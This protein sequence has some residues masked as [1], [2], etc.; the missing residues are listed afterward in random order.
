MG[1]LV[2]LS[3]AT[4]PKAADA[5]YPHR[6]TIP[7]GSLGTPRVS[8]TWTCPSPQ[9]GPSSSGPATAFD[10]VVAV[11]TD[12]VYPRSPCTGLI[13]FHGRHSWISSP[14]TL[15]TVIARARQGPRMSTA[16]SD[17]DLLGPAIAPGTCRLGRGA[18]LSCQSRRGLGSCRLPATPPAPVAGGSRPRGGAGVPAVAS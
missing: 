6:S 9:A 12:G 16:L 14:G 15:V 18:G 5:T 1:S 17:E 4:K 13:D 10:I 2:G 3:N 11:A 8:S 7:R